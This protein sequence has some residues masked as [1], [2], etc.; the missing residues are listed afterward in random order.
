MSDLAVLSQRQVGTPTS[1]TSTQTRSTGCPARTEIES[2]LDT[3]NRLAIDEDVQQVYETLLHASRYPAEVVGLVL[4]DPAQEEFISWFDAQF[5]NEHHSHMARRGWPEGLGVDGSL[6]ELKAGP[7]LPSV[8]IVLITAARLR[9]DARA[10][11]AMPQWI[12]AHERWVQTQPRARHI[13]TP[14]SGHGVHV[15][16]PELVVRAIREVF[17]EPVHDSAADTRR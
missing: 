10:R 9:D 16:Q 13:I 12:G 3:A 8:P 2:T 11:A 7:P 14:D 6:D 5:P 17:D 1:M 4:L 15:E